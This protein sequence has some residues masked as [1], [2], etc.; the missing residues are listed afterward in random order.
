M[1]LPP[2]FAWTDIDSIAAFARANPFATIAH[3]G[4]GGLEAQHIPLLVDVVD[5][6][7]VL[8]G[9][10]ARADPLWRA[11]QALAVFAGPHAYVSASWY[12]E[13]DTVPTWNYLA[14]HAHGA[15]TVVE[16]IDATRALMDRL[17]A[18]ME[19]E[20]SRR[21]LDRLSAQVR[22][23][24]ETMIVWFRIDVDRLEAKAK[25]SQNHAPQRR[26]RAIAGL[27]GAGGDPRTR[28]DASAIADAMERT[29]PPEA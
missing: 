11:T 19:G 28:A 6:R 9:H 24:L 15:V 21:W 12:D 20:A 18:T 8:H 5:G 29:L 14:V 16:S 17:A 10:V 26:R 7:L 23:K 1:Y 13:P 4:A 25:L 22:E 27:R 3:A 2:A